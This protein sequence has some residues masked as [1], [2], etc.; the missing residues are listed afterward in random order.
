[1]K[2]RKNV[3]C[4]NKAVDNIKTHYKIIKIEIRA[5]R[6]DIYILKWIKKGLESLL[7]EYSAWNLNVEYKWMVVIWKLT[8]DQFWF[9]HH[10]ENNLK[11]T[12]QIKMKFIH[13]KI[14]KKKYIEEFYA[15]IQSEVWIFNRMDLWEIK[16]NGPLWRDHLNGAILVQKIT[17]TN[18]NSTSDYFSKIKGIKSRIRIEI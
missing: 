16:I 5:R 17:I 4:I 6:I 3:F 2:Q 15:V 1:M 18:F 12:F 9:S 7:R 13:L 10:F 11:K 8:F 14:I